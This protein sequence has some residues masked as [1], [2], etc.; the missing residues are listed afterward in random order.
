MKK[1][2]LAIFA[3]LLLAGAGI[4]TAVTYQ[5]TPQVAPAT[6]YKA[7]L[8]PADLVPIEDTTFSRWNEGYWESATLRIRSQT[9]IPISVAMLRWDPFEDPSGGGVLHLTFEG[10]TNPNR[11]VVVVYQACWKWNPESVWDTV[12]VPACYAYGDVIGRFEIPYVFLDGTVIDI[13]IT[14]LI[15][16][17]ES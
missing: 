14:A 12:D 9:F 11:G 10:R 17:G 15:R 2:G 1:Q 7:Q 5:V 8:E 13:P 6:V 4:A 16:A 3:G